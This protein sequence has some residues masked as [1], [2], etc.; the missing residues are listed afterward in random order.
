MFGYTE[1]EFAGLSSRELYEAGETWDQMGREAYPILRDGLPYVAEYEMVRN[2]GA[3]FWVRL[4][5]RAVDPQAEHIEVIWTFEDVS[6]RR[7]AEARLAESEERLR[8]IVTAMSE[9]IVLQA[10]DGQIL[11]ANDAAQRMLALTPEQ[12]GDPALRDPEWRSF[13]EDGSPFPPELRPRTVTLR[14]GEAQHRVIMGVQPPGEPIRW[15]SSNAVPLRRTPGEAPYAVVSTFTDITAIRE[16]ERRYRTLFENM[17]E[18][19]TVYKI[20]RDADGKP[21]DWILAEANAEGRRFFGDSYEASVGKTTT[22]LAYGEHMREP[23][24]RSDE[25]T[26][27]LVTAHQTVYFAPSDV[28]YLSAVFAIDGDTIVNAVMDIS[29][30]V[31][32][33]ADLRAALEENEHTVAELRKALADVRT[34]TGLL[35]ICMYCKKVRN[36]DGYW[37][38]IEQYLSEHTDAMLSHGLCPDCYQKYALPDVEALERGRT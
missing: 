8:S 28:W 14:T 22:E 13:Q 27:G 9:G 4:S 6:A 10:A 38:K 19:I 7:A 23:V 5:G 32:A 37:D 3:K 29:E 17:Q 15:V 35:P 30:R 21:V 18:D 24:L 33:E 34:L 12:I 31:R 36:D 16:S 25:Y 11:L 2:G 1:A 20:Q 26:A